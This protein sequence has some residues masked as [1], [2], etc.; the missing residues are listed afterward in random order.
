MILGIDPITRKLVP[1]QTPP[2]W[3]WL[4][5]KLNLAKQGRGISIGEDM[6]NVSAI[7]PVERIEAFV[8]L[9][10]GE[11]VMLDSDL[12]ELYRVTTR[13]LNQAVKRN[14]A[15]FPADFMFRLSAQEKEQ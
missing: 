6:A 7:V 14:L 12:A 5:F 11:K 1:V 10:R 3:R 8:L 15:R 13:A 9:I 2:D 4:R